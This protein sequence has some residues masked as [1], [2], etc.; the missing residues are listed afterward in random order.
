MKLGIK[1][2]EMVEKLIFE[3]NTFYICMIWN[4]SEKYLSYSLEADSQKSI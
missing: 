3:M 2:F 1:F 4:T